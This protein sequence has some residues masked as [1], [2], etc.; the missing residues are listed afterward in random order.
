MIDSFERV[1]TRI[2]EICDERD[3]LNE[4]FRVFV[5]DI[6]FLRSN[7]AWKIMQKEYILRIILHVIEYNWKKIKIRLLIQNVNIKFYIMG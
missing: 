3:I 4:V 5:Q 6:F 1:L 2:R 7:R